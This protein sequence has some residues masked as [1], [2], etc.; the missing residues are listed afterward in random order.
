LDALL[1]GETM[2]DSDSLESWPETHERYAQHFGVDPQLGRE[3]FAQHDAQ[4]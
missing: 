3:A 4:Q 2:S 1:A